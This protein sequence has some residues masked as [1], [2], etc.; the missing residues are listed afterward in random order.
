[1]SATARTAHGA[2]LTAPAGAGTIYRGM[3]SSPGNDYGPN[4]LRGRTALGVGVR[5]RAAYVV[6]CNYL[7]SL[8]FSVY[9]VSVIF[10]VLYAKIP[11]YLVSFLFSALYA[12]CPYQLVLLMQSFPYCLGVNMK[13]VLIM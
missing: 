3:Q 6:P 11:Y 5:L 1:M 4:T 10:S 8:L 2:G 12:K 9:I 7:V 13:S